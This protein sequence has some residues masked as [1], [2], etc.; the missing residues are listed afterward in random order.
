[1]INWESSADRGRGRRPPTRGRGQRSAQYTP[2]KPAPPP[3]GKRP[4][5]G[6]QPPLRPRPH[7]ARLLL[8]NWKG[9]HPLG[10]LSPSHRW[11]FRYA[12]AYLTYP[13]CTIL[14]LNTPIAAESSP[15]SDPAPALLSPLGERMCQEQG[16]Q[17]S[18]FPVSL[19][20]YQGA[21]SSPA[22]SRGLSDWSEM[23]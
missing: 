21:G 5:P 16:P 13:P 19:H 23:S 8:G 20:P 1:M 6:K 11:M 3:P 18:G 2:T 15:L 10:R 4:L 14:C 9:I 7:A 12:P 17:Q 22:L